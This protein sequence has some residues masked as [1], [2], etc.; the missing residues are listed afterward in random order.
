MALRAEE[1][2]QLPTTAYAVLGLLT[3]G[4]MSGYDLLKLVEKSVGFFWAPAKSQVYGELKRLAHAGLISERPVRQEDRPDKRLYRLTAR[5]EAALRAWLDSPEVEPDVVRSALLV[6]LFFGHRADPE[7]LVALV[8]RCRSEAAARLASYRRIEREMAGRDEFFFP[9]LVLRAGL[10]HERAR[11]RWCREVLDAMA[12]R[13]SRPGE[14]SGPVSR[15]PA[16]TAGRRPALG[17][18]GPPTGGADEGRTP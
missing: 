12:A 7:A 15:Q 9:Y 11:L 14:P 6:K 13:G 8:E 16:A 5:G 18:A 3:F 1:A 17:A 2:V 10:I 4:P